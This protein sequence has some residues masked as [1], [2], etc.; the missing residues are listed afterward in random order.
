MPSQDIAKFKGRNIK[1]LIL[2]YEKKPFLIYKDKR[3]IIKQ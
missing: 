2:K 3:M 1:Y